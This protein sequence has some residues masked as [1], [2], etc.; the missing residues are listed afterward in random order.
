[1][2]AVVE[3]HA[4]SAPR[5]VPSIPVQVARASVGTLAVVAVLALVLGG[6]AAASPWLSDRWAQAFGDA[7][8]RLDDG[9]VLSTEPARG[10]II[11]VDA[12]VLG[13]DHDTSAL[14]RAF[15]TP[16]RALTTAAEVQAAG[17]PTPAEQ[18]PGWPDQGYAQT[19]LGVVF[20]PTLVEPGVVRVVSLHGSP[21]GPVVGRTAAERATLLTRAV[22]A[23]GWSAGGTPRVTVT[24]VE[25][26]TDRLT[27]LTVVAATP[28]ITGTDLDAVGNGADA[29]A[30]FTPEGRLDRL[31]LWPEPIVRVRDVLVQSPA[32]AWA[33]LRHHER[34]AVVSPGSFHRAELMA[35]YDVAP[36]SGYPTSPVWVLADSQGLT[37]ATISAATP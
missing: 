4:V 8:L 17:G 2:S 13:L 7:S 31:I 30:F 14:G 18:A 36:G 3:P 25:R 24:V 12:K 22:D 34:D 16:V 6:V 32:S 35:G 20:Y 33:D 37:G 27:G 21:T 26:G 1:M 19:P 11:T 28:S 15:G 10:A 9:V 5:P 29:L 23:L